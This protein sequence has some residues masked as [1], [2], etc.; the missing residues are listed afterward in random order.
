MSKITIVERG[1]AKKV[2]EWFKFHKDE[3]YA[4]ILEEIVKDS[5]DE[6]TLR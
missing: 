3:E 1:D 5:R 2:L 4:A 6:L